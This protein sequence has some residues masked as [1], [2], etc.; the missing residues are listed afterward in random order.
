MVLEMKTVRFPCF[1][2]KIVISFRQEKWKKSM[3][4]LR[5]IKAPGVEVNEIDLSQ[6]SLRY[7]FSNTT[8]VML[9]GFTDRGDDYMTDIVTSIKGFTDKFGSPTNEAERYLYNAVKETIRGGGVPVVSRLPYSNNSFEKYTYTRYLASSNLETLADYRIEDNIPSS[10]EGVIT[11]S[12]DSTCFN[13]NDK[14]SNPI[15]GRFWNYVKNIGSFGS[16]P[17]D[18]SEYAEDK[19]FTVAFLSGLN[20]IY[21]SDDKNAKEVK[22]IL[23]DAGAGEKPEDFIS[24]YYSQLTLDDI[25]EFV[26]YYND[27]PGTTEISEQVFDDFI[28]AAKYCEMAKEGSLTSFIK[29]S[30]DTTSSYSNYMD[31]DTYDNLLIGNNGYLQ[32]GEIDIVDITKTRYEKD[33]RIAVGETAE[34]ICYGEYIGILPVLVAPANALVAQR[35][36]AQSKTGFRDTYNVISDLR[37]V[38][39]K[40]PAEDIGMDRCVDDYDKLTELVNENDK[41]TIFSQNLGSDDPDEMTVGMYAAS[42]FPAIDRT[43]SNSL[44]DTYL[45]QIGLVVYR[46]YID[47]SNYGRIKF[48]PIESYVG[49]LDRDA[50]DPITGTSIYIENVVNQVSENVRLFARFNFK[51]QAKAYYKASTY[52]VENQPVVSLGFYEDDIVKK[53]DTKMLL[54]SLE[55]IFKKLE[56]PNMLKLDLLV[57]AG[58]SNI[59]QNIASTEKTGAGFYDVEKKYNYRIANR[60]ALKDWQSVLDK[61]DYFCSKVRKDLMFLADSP[62]NLA[63]QSNYKLVNRRTTAGR[64][65]KRDIIPNIKHLT[66]LNTSYGA[67]Y[68]TWLLGVDDTSHGYIWLPPSIKAL[69]SYLVSDRD[70]NFWSAPAGL[71]RGRMSRVYDVAFN[72]TEQDAE[73]IYTNRWNYCVSYPTDGIILEGQKTFQKEATAFDRVNVR[74]LFLKVEK[75]I[76]KM[77]KGVLYEQFSETL[78]TNF[79]DKINNYLSDIQTR[80]GIRD[81]YV[82]CDRRNNTD[83]TIDRNELHC[84]IGIRPTKT[85]EFIVLN[86]IC[87]NQS[88]NVE[89]IVSKYA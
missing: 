40:D 33:K 86:F 41:I 43:S 52:L 31:Y 7:D 62:R 71:A 28:V 22:Q 51:D 29:L 75:D 76:K 46:M 13:D 69:E 14:Y 42:N 11:L 80:D 59:A 88:A 19:L 84:T 49:S 45:K 16:R 53:I 83:E 70:Y 65:I 30:S 54:N 23:V 47:N 37:P 73:T 63:L 8:M 2:L 21:E 72:P 77:A 56:N 6:Y 17:R 3:A 44:D 35:A 32:D 60:Y 89:E 4:T 18:I 81:F 10:I 79:R 85:V 67:G 9:N 36:I 25:S 26:Q 66:G 12:T 34:D 64:T 58:I 74:R 39:R 20:T 61:Y 68:S 48:V 82:I 50:K 57:D 38:H 78:M 24:N 15:V 27:T 1:W 55:V 87:T 5:T